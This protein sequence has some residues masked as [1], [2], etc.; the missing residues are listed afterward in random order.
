MANLLNPTIRLLQTDPDVKSYIYQQI[1]DFEPYVT[2]QTLVAVLARDPRKLAIQLETEGREID[3]KDLKKMHRI[4]IVLREGDASLEEEALH[5]D[6]YEAIREAKEKLIQK[7][8]A[9]Q[10]SVVTNQE[11]IEQINSA[12]QNTLIH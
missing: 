10:D 8:A 4:A 3:P 9:I 7:L 12:L 2:P 6:L 1:T 11:R 5:E